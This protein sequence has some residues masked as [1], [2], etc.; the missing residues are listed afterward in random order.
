[1]RSLTRCEADLSYWA[2]Y[3]TSMPSET[4][5]S[6]A[7][8]ARDTDGSKMQGNTSG[9]EKTRERSMNGTL[10]R[11]SEEVCAI[12]HLSND[13]YEQQPILME[14][15]LDNILR[16]R[17]LVTTNA[18][19]PLHAASQSDHGGVVCRW[20]LKVMFS[21]V[22]RQQKKIQEECQ[23]CTWPALDH[24]GNGESSGRRRCARQKRRRKPDFCKRAGGRSFA[25]FPACRQERM[26]RE[27]DWGLLMIGA[28]SQPV[29]RKESSSEGGERVAVFEMIK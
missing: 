27:P 21:M 1:M 17:R 25:P 7:R 10:L 29:G 4:R 23:L 8:V 5:R 18:I 6:D 15:G 28:R 11:K 14:L 12:L 2:K 22:G 19:Y 26:E 20:Q 24:Q 9:R 13:S 16:K 3:T